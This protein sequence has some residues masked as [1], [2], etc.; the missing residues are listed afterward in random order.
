MLK[1]FSK[2]GFMYSTNLESMLIKRVEKIANI[3]FSTIPIGS[4]IIIKKF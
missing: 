4:P 1:V 2:L 3:S